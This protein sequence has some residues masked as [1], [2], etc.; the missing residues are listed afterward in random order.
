VAARRSISRALK[1][2][3]SRIAAPSASTAQQLPPEP[4][5]SM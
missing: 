5:P 2:V 1:P 4:D 3:S